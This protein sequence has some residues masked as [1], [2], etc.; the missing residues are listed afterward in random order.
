MTRD[1]AIKLQAESRHYRRRGDLAYDDA[2]E[3]DQFDF[4]TKDSLFEEARKYWSESDGINERLK[5]AGFAD[6]LEPAPLHRP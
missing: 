5:A 4:N 6:L 2:K 1:E 3:C